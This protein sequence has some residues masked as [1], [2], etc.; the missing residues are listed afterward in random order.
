LKKKRGAG[1]GKKS[2]F[3][4]VMCA[5]WGFGGLTKKNDRGEKRRDLEMRKKK[6]RRGERT[7]QKRGGKNAVNAHREGKGTMA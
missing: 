5:T 6:R 2:A 3:C 7:G 1:V 4:Q